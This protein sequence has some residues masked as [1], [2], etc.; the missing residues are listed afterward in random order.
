MSCLGLKVVIFVEVDTGLDRDV[1]RV[2]KGSGP[3]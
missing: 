3:N 1:L 2:G